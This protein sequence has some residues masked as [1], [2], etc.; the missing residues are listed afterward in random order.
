MLTALQSTD[1]S[2]STSHPPFARHS[3]WRRVVSPCHEPGR[4]CCALVKEEDEDENEN[5]EVEEF[6]EADEET[7]EADAPRNLKKEE[8]KP[9][10]PSPRLNPWISLILTPRSS[11]LLAS[12][13]R[14]TG[15]ITLWVHIDL[16]DT[17]FAI[18][19]SLFLS[20]RLYK[21][22]GGYP[23]LCYIE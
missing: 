3:A 14:R 22:S 18:I 20:T 10:T 15:P 21:I 16:P 7:D 6:K 9:V 23:A 13:A 2:S 11:L 5:E 1:Q 8:A 4:S 17:Q 19:Q 12:P